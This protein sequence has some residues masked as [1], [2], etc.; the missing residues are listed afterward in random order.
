VDLDALL[1]FAYASEVLLEETGWMTDASLDELEQT[2]A[3]FS[4]RFQ[5]WLATL[6]KKLGPPFATRRSNP[7]LAEDLYF[8]AFELAAWQHRSGYLVL[9]CGQHDR[10]TPVFVSFGYREASAA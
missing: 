2:Y 5:R 4:D 3:D 8:E 10:D 9:A 7:A 6:D 1:N